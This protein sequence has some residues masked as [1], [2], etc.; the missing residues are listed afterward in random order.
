[1][2]CRERKRMN[3]TEWIND[4]ASTSTAGAVEIMPVDDEIASILT[5]DCVGI[6]WA[7]EMRHPFRWVGD[8]NVNVSQD[9][10]LLGFML[11]EFNLVC[12]ETTP[13]T[14]DDYQ[15]FE[16]KPR[17]SNGSF[18][19]NMCT[20]E[21]IYSWSLDIKQC[22]LPQQNTLNDMEWS[23]RCLLLCIKKTRQKQCY[24]SKFSQFELAV[25]Y[26]LNIFKECCDVSGWLQEK[27]SCLYY[28]NI[29]EEASKVV[30]HLGKVKI[31]LQTA[32][33]ACSFKT[34]QSFIKVLGAILMVEIPDV[35]PGFVTTV[36]YNDSTVWCSTAPKNEWITLPE[37][38]TQGPWIPVANGWMSIENILSESEWCNHPC[39]LECRIVGTQ[40]DFL[41][42]GQVV[43]CDVNQGFLCRDENQINAC[44]RY[45]V[46]LWCC[47]ETFHEFVP[48]PRTEIIPLLP[49]FEDEEE[50]PLPLTEEYSYV[51]DEIRIFHDTFTPSTVQ[52]IEIPIQDFTVR[53]TYPKAETS[54][55]RFTVRRQRHSISFDIISRYWEAWHRMVKKPS[56]GTG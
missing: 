32:L 22:L 24:L 18:Q 45:E 9:R 53:Q 31:C 10:S 30:G 7:W 34:V 38:D 37:G 43:T 26:I 44:Y 11:S 49:H 47:D 55:Q 35:K 5:P 19:S 40:L 56:M 8:F 36:T 17:P 12:I 48:V 15:W 51:I 2:Q 50:Y 42:S 52:Y 25:Q 3:A 33:N 46:R 54:F 6:D 16:W 21:E 1:M 13:A 39:R 4:G 41:K 20:N 14:F 23:L 28:G 29:H 27:F